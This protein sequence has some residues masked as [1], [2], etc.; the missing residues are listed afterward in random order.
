[1]NLDDLFLEYSR[2]KTELV[3]YE[4]GESPQDSPD[5][6]KMYVKDELEKI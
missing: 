5:V 3:E 4:F 2:F 6:G 1:M